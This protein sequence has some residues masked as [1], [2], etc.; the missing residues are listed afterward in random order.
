[1]SK[2]KD[3]DF[4]PPEEDDDRSSIE[5]YENESLAFVESEDDEEQT[6][7]KPFDLIEGPTVME[8][9]ATTKRQAK[10]ARADRDGFTKLDKKRKRNARAMLNRLVSILHQETAACNPINDTVNN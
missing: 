5:F 10:A 7:G 3:Q 4:T 1:M 2:A 6:L 8:D 9:D